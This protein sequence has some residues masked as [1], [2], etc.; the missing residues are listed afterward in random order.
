MRIIGDVHGK[1]DEYLKIVKGCDT[2]VQV[3]DMGFNYDHMQKL[4]YQS[5]CFVPGNHD[6]YN[7]IKNNPFVNVYA[8]KDFGYCDAVGDGGEP[9][10][11]Y[12]RGAHSIDKNMRVENVDWW[13]DEELSYKRLSEAICYYNRIQHSNLKND[14]VITHEAPAQI[15]NMFPKDILY[16]FGYCPNWNSRTAHALQMM[17]ESY[18]PKLWI[19]GHFHQP[20]DITVN[21]TRFI[22]LPE[23]AYIDVDR[24][25]NVKFGEGF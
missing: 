18:Q 13:E 3:G 14:L 16:R 23:L 5:H 12:V 17:W 9:D 8:T 1:T 19:F 11:F 25:L 24:D 2:S 15:A 10:F 21:E 7:E 6:N 22:C 20:L 4:D